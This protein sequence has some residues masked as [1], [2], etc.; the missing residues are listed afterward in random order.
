MTSNRKIHLLDGS[1]YIYR[2]YYA[3]PPLFTSQGIPTNAVI[4]FAKMLGRLF[5]DERPSHLAIAFD[6]KQKTFRH[7]IFSEYKANREG[8]PEDLEPQFE[9]I[10]E[11]VTAMDIPLFVNPGFEADDIIAT[12]AKKAAQEGHDVVMVSADKD[13]MQLVSDRITMFDPMKDIH[14]DRAAVLKKFGVPPLRMQ[15][16]Q[17]LTGDTSDNIPGVPKVGPKSAAKLITAFG[18]LEAV[19]AGVAQL[20][21]P[22]AFE[23]SVIENADVARLSKR[24]ATL[25][26]GVPVTL[27][28]D[29]LK[30]ELARS[31]KLAAFLTGL[32]A[33]GLL[34]ELGLDDQHVNAEQPKTTD[35][36]KPVD[37]QTDAASKKILSGDTTASISVTAPIDRSSYQT[38]LDVETLEREL[39]AA[40]QAGRFCVDLETTSLQANCAD[41][42]GI[43]MC[44]EGRNAVY[45]PLRHR[46]L[47]APQQLPISQVLERIKPLMENSRIGKMGQNL[48]YDL[49]VFERAGINLEGICHDSMIAAHVLDPSKPSYSLDSLAREKLGHK[50]IRYSDVTREGKKQIGFDEV[51]IDRATTY[52]A[53]D[54]DVALRLCLLFE[55][56]LKDA[57]LTHLYKHLELPL[58]PVLAAMEK[59]GVALDSDKLR[60]LGK[61]F[62]KRLLDIEA[63]AYDLAG[64][65]INL[66]S[67]KQ[68]AHLFF[69]KLGYPVIKR[70]KTGPSTDQS[71]LEKLA[72]DFALPGVVLEHR[73]LSKLCSTYV[74]A[75][76]RMVDATTHRLHTNFNQTG[77]ATGRLSSSNPNLQN[78]PIRSSDGRRI[79]TAFVAP[80]N[81][82]LVSADY[83]QIELRMLAH[84]SQDENFVRAF[85][86][87][88]DIHKNTAKEVLTAGAEPS[89]E[90]RR[91]AKAINFGIMYGLSAHGLSKQLG[92]S[93]N[94]AH[95]FIATYFSRYPKIREFMDGT[96]E[97]A[98]EHGYVTTLAGRR[99]FLPDLCSKN[100][101]VRQAAERI[102]MN[103]PIQ[104][105]AA[106]LIK[107]AMIHVHRALEERRLKSRM[108]LQ[109]HDELVLEVSN[110]EHDE[111]TDL[112]RTCMTGVMSLDVPLEVDIGLGKNWAEAH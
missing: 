26:D 78:I 101:N 12:L 14:V 75:L 100:T 98:R 43:A 89:P 68:L 99:R 57:E 70:T 23:R 66:A 90:D 19:I 97:Q 1:G 77:T 85:Q 35:M 31:E 112:V 81:A 62:S 74:D 58:I 55:K 110:E 42:V 109:V 80:K 102:A 47:G 82:R 51:P 59:N 65:T 33:Y 36:S 32:E 53:E 84:L 73:Q 111:V 48:K 15:D 25:S 9:L 67:P 40:E 64:T 20:E 63:R 56:A 86:Q 93:R 69:E 83:S 72:E 95:D 27:D 50:T 44:V 94:A 4:G 52:A 45:V 107:L 54:A 71:V 16:F 28:L 76:P 96:I 21:K 2:A 6:S 49:L 13:L 11:L 22:K 106:D 18:D 8:P 30:F 88:E 10:H 105:S 29:V 79:R 87:G 17:A 5:K 41:I 103:T 24:L 3:V 92:I 39:K 60:G 7:S 108:L 91:R 34:R 61:E 46:Y 37:F 104:G 38:I